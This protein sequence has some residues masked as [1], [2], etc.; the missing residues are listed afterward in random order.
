MGV[1]MDIPW[2]C[3]CEVAGCENRRGT[4]R[5]GVPRR[6]KEGRSSNPDEVDDLEVRILGGDHLLEEGV[7]VCAHPMV[8]APSSHIEACLFHLL[9]EGILGGVPSPHILLQADVIVDICRPG[10]EDP[11]VLLD[12]GHL[13]HPDHSVPGPHVV[14]LGPD[15]LKGGIL[16][17][18]DVLH[19]RG[20]GVVGVGELLA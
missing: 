6:K 4:P 10:R 9:S 18:V 12:V 17:L 13:G 15:I 2:V 11:G 1:G 19:M 5:V 14:H 8:E 7:E 3:D 16:A 20:D